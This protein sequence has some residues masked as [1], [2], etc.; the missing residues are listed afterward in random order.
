[1]I[2]KAK[3]SYKVSL[4]DKTKLNDKTEL[5]YITKFDDCQLPGLWLLAVFYFIEEFLVQPEK[6]RQVAVAVY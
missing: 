1:M 2:D 3:L 4:D 5:K 6:E